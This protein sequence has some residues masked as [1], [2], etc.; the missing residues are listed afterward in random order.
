[1]NKIILTLSNRYTG[2]VVK[3]AYSEKTF[4]YNPDNKLKNGIYVCT[5][6]E[7]DGPNDTS[8]KLSREGVYRISCGLTAHGYSARFGDKPKR[9]EKGYCVNLPIVFDELNTI[10][11]HPIYAWMNWVCVNS[12]QEDIFQT[13]LELVDISYNK[14]IKSYNAKMENLP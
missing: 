7:D 11:P 5:I 1:M 2:I 13:F 4:F 6:K 14:A 3:Q 9:A 10:M 8:A 12:P